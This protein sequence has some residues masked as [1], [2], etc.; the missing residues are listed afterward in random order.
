VTHPRCPAVVRDAAWLATTEAGEAVPEIV[1][2]MK[3]QGVSLDDAKE[4]AR[5]MLPLVL[6]IR[7]GRRKKDV[8]N[9]MRAMIN[10][11]TV[12]GVRA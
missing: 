1:L 8:E 3:N 9:Y 7:I 12:T 4:F 2:E 11:I 10:W 5:E 6:E